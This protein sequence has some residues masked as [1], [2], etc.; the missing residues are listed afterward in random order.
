[1]KRQE[2]WSLLRSLADL[3]PSPW[4]VC[5]DFNE[6]LSLGE[7]SSQSSRSR[8]Q[9]MLFQN[10]LRD[11]YLW[12]LGY[13]GQKFTWSNGRDG[14]DLT[15][16]RLD[17]AVANLEW[18]R[19][20]NVVDVEV[21]PRYCSDHSP[22]VISFDR[23]SSIPWKKNRR[24]HF[25][26]GWMK[27]ADH[28]NMVR[29]VW[30]V[31]N[32]SFGDDKW[33][34]L[35]DRLD[36]CRKN[37]KCWAR[38]FDDKEC[39][40]IKQV[41]EELNM[42]QQERDPRKV[43]KESFLKENLDRLLEVQEL[44]WRQRAKENWLKFGDRNTKYFH[45]CAS[46]KKCRNLVKEIVDLD[47]KRWYSQEG[48]EGAFVRYFQWLYKAESVAEI[49]PCINSITPKVSPE[50][51]QSLLAPV[52]M[53]EIQTA[54]NQMDPLKAPGPDGF[55][56]CFFQQNWEILH[57][58]VCDAISYF[59][60]TCNLNA[61]I[62]ATIIALVPKTKNP[63]SVNDFR[64]I[65]L[66][67]VTY[68]ILSKILANRLKRIMSC[69]IS[70]LQ[71]AFISGRLI[72][73]NII[74]AYET[75]HTMQ[76]RLWGRSGYMGVK[77]D[78]SKA[79]DRVEWSFLEA[80]MI[81]LGFAPAWV[82]MIMACVKTVNYSVV[83][84]GNVVGKIF[85]LR[86]L[87]QGDPISPYLFIICAEVFS[88]LLQNAQMKGCISG[89]PTSKKGPKITH[90]F[91]ADDNLVFCKANRVEWRRLLN[92]IETY[93]RGSGQKINLVKTAVFF[94]RNT[95]QSRRKEIKASFGLG[96]ANNYDSYLGLP[97]LVGKNRNLAF[98]EIKEKV[99]R[100]EEGLVM[101]AKCCVHKIQADSLLA[102]AMAALFALDFCLD[103]GLANIV[104]EGDSLQV[105]KGI[106][107]EDGQQD[108]IGHFLLG[109]SQRASCFSVCKWSHCCREANVVA[110]LLARKASSMCLSC[111]WI[112]VLPLFMSSAS[113]RD[114]LVS[115][116]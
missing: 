78:M 8:R 61:S 60:D 38:F 42:L 74:A 53:E 89:V 72:S 96:E 95:C 10:T 97:T 15:L 25:E 86:G 4:L 48:I 63:I 83:V 30:K 103:L 6:I 24:F 98:K 2:S 7:K 50:M 26:A 105:I 44:K 102:E 88:A 62:N 66:C 32:R 67:N 16:E 21:M 107:N 20:F 45:A 87:R 82:R 70:G 1:M 92:L 100:N 27:H 13:K 39:L 71:S 55:P 40:A 43:D 37:Y 59:F 46:Q 93:E 31:K 54:L 14:R 3:H 81:K 110:H 106:C 76:T 47:G 68:K 80:V 77:L 51:N 52:T 12:D 57:Q 35:K 84:N 49:G 19:V 115:K 114:F 29:R 69:I 65:S 22:L 23:S 73:N 75:L 101:G 116:L 104:C 11:C 28:K 111:C 64:P 99:I 9:M 94:S 91:F 79:Y 41:E 5:G 33:V 18:S 90:L 109:I 34:I 17:R 36:N 112:E 108:R 56:A 85:P 58:E 113:L